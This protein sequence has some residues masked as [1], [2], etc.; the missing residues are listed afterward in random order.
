MRLPAAFVSGGIEGEDLG[1]RDRSELRSEPL[2]HAVGGRACRLAFIPWLQRDEHQ[3]AVWGVDAELRSV[4]LEDDRNLRILVQNPFDAASD[5]LGVGE[6]RPFRKLDRDVEIAD[7]L[8]W[9]KTGRNRLV[10]EVRPHQPERE[11]RQHENAPSHQRRQ[12]RVV[13]VPRRV[14]HPVD[15]T[16]EPRPVNGVLAEQQGRKRRRKRQCNEQRDRDR[17]RD[18][19]RE[20]L[21]ELAGRPR[22][23]RDRDEHRQ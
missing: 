3:R 16:V 21:V 22:E 2:D 4:R 19:E 1:G 15:R 7:V 20:L 9:E 12:D 23:E 14:D 13:A 11:Q 6:R 17:A 10:R 8:V 5:A 18:G